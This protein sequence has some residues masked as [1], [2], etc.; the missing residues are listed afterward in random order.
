MVS[1]IVIAALNSLSV[2]YKKRKL[3]PYF[4][5]FAMK[6]F[7]LS[8]ATY[9]VG[10]IVVFWAYPLSFIIFFV[11]S[12]FAGR[13]MGAILFVV[14]VSLSLYLFEMKLVSRFAF[15]LLMLIIFCDVLVGVLIKMESQL[16][17]LAIRDPLTDAYNRRHMNVCLETTIEEI[18]RDFGPACL[19]VLDVDYFKKI[20]DEHGHSVG[21]KVL[22][23]L[24]SLLHKRKRKLDFV[25]RTGGEE[26]VLLLRNTSMRQAISFA[27]NIRKAVEETELVNSKTITISLGVAEYQSGETEDAWLN[28]AD[29][30]LY[31]AK[32]NG[33]NCVCPKE[34]S[35]FDFQI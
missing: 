6:L 25:F 28:R 9:Y 30:N 13:I 24:V 7:T 12:R 33:R 19:I 23:N 32:H 16:S 14:M 18:R 22:I 1:L 34:A 31:K 11:Q 20:N 5:F 26:F 17:E 2:F 27:E 10:S 21:D 35:P 29:E 3:I 8:Y 15:T 4:F